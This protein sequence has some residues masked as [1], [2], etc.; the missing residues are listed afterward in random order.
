M[1]TEDQQAAAAAAAAAIA[2]VVTHW[3]ARELLVGRWRLARQA[4]RSMVQ[5]RRRRS[6]RRRAAPRPST[7][8]TVRRRRACARTAA[9]SSPQTE[10]HRPLSLSELKC[11]VSW[12]LRINEMSTGTD[13]AAPQAPPGWKGSGRHGQPIPGEIPGGPKPIVWRGMVLNSKVRTQP[14]SAPVATPVRAMPL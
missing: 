11:H 14:R 13:P 6:R 2:M 3:M 7:A 5:S 10:A 1:S 9:P 4:A 12:R 8:D